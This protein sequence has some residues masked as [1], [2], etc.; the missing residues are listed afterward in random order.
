MDK[1]RARSVLQNDAERGEYPIR[2]GR[3]TTAAKYTGLWK[4]MR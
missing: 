1:N 2:E 3:Q 4:I